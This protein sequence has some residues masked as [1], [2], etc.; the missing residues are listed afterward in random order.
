MP[1]SASSQDIVYLLSS[2]VDL[3]KLKNYLASKPIECPKLYS[4]N[5]TVS[6]LARS[7]FLDVRQ[8]LFQE[9]CYR[10]FLW[11]ISVCNNA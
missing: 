3:S 6:T 1:E 8:E 2:Y 11:K 10:L 7:P 4:R 9:V 5:N